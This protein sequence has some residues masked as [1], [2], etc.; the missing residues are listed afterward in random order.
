VF[1]G[2]HYPSDLLG[3]ACVG[4]GT[5]CMINGTRIRT[6]FGKPVLALSE[7]YPGLFYAGFFLFSWQTAVLFD[8]L[9]SLASALMVIK[10]H[11]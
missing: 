6:M 2:L 3:G 11:F 8:D 7:K 10:D 1:L 9:R 5:V 4:I